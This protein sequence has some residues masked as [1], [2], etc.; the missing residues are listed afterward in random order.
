M[1]NL[2]VLAR[3]EGEAWARWR[4]H[5][6]RALGQPIPSHWPGIFAVAYI[7]AEDLASARAIHVRDIQKLAQLINDYAAETWTALV[8][9]A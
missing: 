9:A 8:Q 4:L 7:T 3:R 1:L 5:Q 2:E 6:L